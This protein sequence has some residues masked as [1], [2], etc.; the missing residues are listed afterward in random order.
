MTIRKSWY[1]NRTV[2]GVLRQAQDKFASAVAMKSPAS[3]RDWNQYNILTLIVCFTSFS[4][5]NA[6]D[7]I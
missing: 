3:Y 5:C 6:F 1:E 4:N 7:E 2:N